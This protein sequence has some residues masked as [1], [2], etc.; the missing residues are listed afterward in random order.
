MK[1][2]RMA[3]FRSSSALVA[4]VCIGLGLA[5]L[6]GAQHES[7]RSESARDPARAT[8]TETYKRVAV[9][10]PR[11][12]LSFNTFFDAGA[13]SQYGSYRLVAAFPYQTDQM[14]VVLEGPP[15]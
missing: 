2:E 11:E 1:G 9:L 5:M 14:Y 4:G 6:L 15:K 13:G 3:S 10:A 7:T 12:P 8:G